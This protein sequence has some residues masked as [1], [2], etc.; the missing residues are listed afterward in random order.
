MANVGTTENMKLINENR[1]T[2]TPKKYSNVMIDTTATDFQIH[3]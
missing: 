1:S 2:C 3:G